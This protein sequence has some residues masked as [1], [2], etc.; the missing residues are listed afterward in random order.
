MLAVLLTMASAHADPIE[1]WSRDT[2]PEQ[3]LAGTDGWVSGYADDPW[4]GS[5]STNSLL[6]QTDDN[7]GAFGDGGAHDNWLVRGPAFTHAI[8]QGRVGNLDDDTIGFVL[9]H[10]KVDAYY[11]LLH[12]ADSAPDPIE[13]VGSP[14]LALLRIDGTDVE[15]LAEV[16]DVGELAA[17]P[18]SLMSLERRGDRLIGRLGNQVIIDETDPSPLGPGA[19][20]AYSYDAGDENGRNNETAYISEIA[21]LALDDDDDD[22]ADDNDNCPGVLNPAQ[23]DPDNDGLGSA[24]DNCPQVA[25]PDQADGD[26]DGVGDACAPQPGDSGDTGDTSDTGT[27]GGTT[28]SSGSSGSTS[29]GGDTGGDRGPDGGIDGDPFADEVLRAAQCE[30][31]GGGSP[32]GLALLL[33]PL[34]ALRRRRH[35]GAGG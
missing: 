35:D 18:G 10:D 24:C 32:S 27:D 8:V 19:A 25:N 33:L 17:P 11:L 7:G 12:S 2:F 20:G 16:G 14:T 22:Q 28:G 23:A 4:T 3:D 9:S 6:P 15:V 21:L 31:C 30:G 1:V 26:S 13:E 5:R 34:A 29:G